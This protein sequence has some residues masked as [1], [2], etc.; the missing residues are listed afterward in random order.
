[1]RLDLIYEMIINKDMQI[2][3]IVIVNKI[4]FYRDSFSIE[5]VKFIKELLQKTKFILIT[6]FY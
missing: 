6:P 5:M 2:Q 1:M 3:I 4:L